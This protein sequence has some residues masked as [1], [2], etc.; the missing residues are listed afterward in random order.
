MSDFHE[1]HKGD[2]V[3]S[4]RWPS[5]PGTVVNIDENTGA[6][7]PIKVDWE[8][9][10]FG[11]GWYAPHELDIIESDE[12]PKGDPF[13]WDEDDTPAEDL[14]M[15]AVNPPLP[16]GP[17]SKAIGLVHGPRGRDYDHPYVD[18]LRTA[19]IFRAMTGVELSVTQAVLFM[20]A[21]KMSRFRASPNVEDHLV[22]AAGYIEC[23]SMVREREA[24]LSEGGF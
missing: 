16:E 4:L 9:K 23:L 18:Y 22:D 20:V 7:W 17:L 12:A 11:F 6:Q 1:V 3:R 24:I 2:I 15:D 21:V 8:N 13:A 10:A 5:G 19:D 14:V